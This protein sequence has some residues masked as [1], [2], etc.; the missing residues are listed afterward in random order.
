MEKAN[1]LLKSLEQLDPYS[2][3]DVDKI[4]AR[5]EETRDKL[6]GQLIRNYG[7]TALRS[8][9]AYKN[10]D[11]FYADLPQTKDIKRRRAILKQMKEEF[12]E[13]AQ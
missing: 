6:T 10:L 13:G 12:A 1:F 8:P 5:Y 7:E 3:D 4:I 11:E 9:A 2:Y